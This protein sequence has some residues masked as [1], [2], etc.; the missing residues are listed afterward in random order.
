VVVVDISIPL[1]LALLHDCER[2]RVDQVGPKGVGEEK[3][4]VGRL[5]ARAH[6]NGTSQAMLR[7][8]TGSLR[9]G[10]TLASIG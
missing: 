8:I 6:W 4:N 1:G 10:R 7:C 5:P 2:V 9:D 3:E